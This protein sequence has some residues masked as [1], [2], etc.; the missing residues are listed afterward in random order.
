MNEIIP[1]PFPGMCGNCYLLKNGDNYV[2]VDTALRTKRNMLEEKLDELG[3]TPEKLK[4]IVLT[5]GDFDHSGNALY[6]G[7]K[8]DSPVAMHREDAPITENGRMFIN[9][10]KKRTLIDWLSRK[11][12]QIDTFTPDIYM[13]DGMDLNNYGVKAKILHLPGH[14][15][16]SIG[17]L[18]A[19]NDLLCGDLL[20]NRKRPRLYYVDDAGA[21]QKSIEKLKQYEIRV[22]Y[23]GH[24]S[25]FR[26]TDF[27]G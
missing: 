21:V 7:K 15:A 11:F 6:L 27:S 22:V 4:L 3:C 5:H 26:F 23:P 9:K 1:I 13:E 19:E 25:A 17:V 16:G 24:G 2:L 14:S 12:L 18:T 8:Y 10:K 20:E